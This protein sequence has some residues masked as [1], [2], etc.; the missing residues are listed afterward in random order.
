VVIHLSGPP[1]D[2]GGRA[3][4]PCLAL[5]RVGFT[6]PTGRPVAGALLPHL[7]TLART[8]FVAAGGVFSVALSFRSP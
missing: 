7:F 5:L 2:F 4:L 6:K 8:T 3:A 1:G